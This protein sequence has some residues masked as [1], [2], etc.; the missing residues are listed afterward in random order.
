MQFVRFGVVAGLLLSLVYLLLSLY[1]RSL[2]RERLENDWAGLDAAAQAQTE[3][4]AYVAAGL[5]RYERGLWRW[6]LLL[7][8]VLPGLALAWLVYVIN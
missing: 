3:R 7:V 4:E 2:R 5:R 1:L 8:Y 6:L